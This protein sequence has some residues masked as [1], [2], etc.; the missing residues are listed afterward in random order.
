MDIKYLGKIEYNEAYKLQ[1]ELVNLRNEN[2]IPDTL[3]LLEHPPVVVLGRNAKQENILVPKKTLKDKGIAVFESNR[4]GDVTLHCPGQLVGYP[5]IDLKQNGKDIHVYLRKL[6]QVLISLLGDYGIKA[7]RIEGYTGVW[8]EKEKIASL[9][10]AARNW[11]VYHGFALNVNNDPDG[12]SV[13]NPCGIRGLKVT[14]MS[15]LL[16]RKVSLKEVCPGLVR[17][18]TEIMYDKFVVQS[19]IRA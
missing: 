15:K 11:V 19:K 16:D 18:F 7:R 13:I 10:I 4:G 14:S 8:V 1:L 3:L 17:H 5:V 9:G 12:F 2:K 6:E